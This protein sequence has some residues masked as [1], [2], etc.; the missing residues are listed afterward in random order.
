MK[1]NNCFRKP[2]LC[3][4]HLQGRNGEQVGVFRRES[5]SLVSSQLLNFCSSIFFKANVFPCKRQ[6]RHKSNLSQFLPEEIN[7]LDDNDNV[8]ET[9]IQWTTGFLIHK[10]HQA[11]VSNHPWSMWN[12]MMW[13]GMI[14]FRMTF[15]I[16]RFDSWRFLVFFVNTSGFSVVRA[17]LI[18]I[19]RSVNSICIVITIR[20]LHLDSIFFQRKKLFKCAALLTFKLVKG[21]MVLYCEKL[22]FQEHRVRLY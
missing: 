11:S 18:H 17:C 19:G 6:Q 21:H 10:L 4:C 16:Y 9:I 3:G 22:R 7:L 2:N 5:T 15:W 20:T 1:W 14:V 13:I 12:M 8:M